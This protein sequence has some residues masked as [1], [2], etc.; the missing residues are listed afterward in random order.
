MIVNFKLVKIC[1]SLKKIKLVYG[2]I[3]SC[4][5]KLIFGYKILCSEIVFFSFFPFFLRLTLKKLKIM[6][7][8]LKSLNFDY[9][10]LN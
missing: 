7:K 2:L 4:I 6:I 10:L 1:P 5:E 8:S 3:V 9:V